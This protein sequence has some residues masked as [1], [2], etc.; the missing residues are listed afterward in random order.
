MRRFVKSSVFK[1]S[2][3]LAKIAKINVEDSNNHASHNKIDLG[4]TADK[5]VK[6]LLVQQ[7]VSDKRVLEFQMECKEFLVNVVSKL[8]AKA[9][10]QYSLMRNVTCLDPKKMLDNHDDLVA[11]FKRVL[12]TLHGAK[13]VLE[14]ECDT[15]LVLYRQFIEEVPL[16]CPSEFK[17]FDPK[18][19]S[20]VDSFL[21]HHMGQNISYRSLWKVVADL[22][23]L[24]HG[25]ASVERGFSVNK[26]IEKLK[27]KTSRNVRSLPNE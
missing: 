3:T 25:Q 22:L 2:N 8:A 21:Y 15:L 23:L 24:S 10:I 20:R 1:A 5:K 18:S 7:K 26:Q 19:D 27:L 16:T 6:E 12:T 17:N 9:P 14:P 11:K 4:F 13:N